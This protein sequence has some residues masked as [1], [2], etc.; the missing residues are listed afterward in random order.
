MTLFRTA[1]LWLLVS[2]AGFTQAAP[3]STNHTVVELLAEN[4]AVIPGQPFWIAYRLEAAPGWHTY[5][6]NPGDSGLPSEINWQLPDGWQVGE[7]YWPSP[8]LISAP[9]FATHA[10][11][12]EVLLL[13][14]ITPPDQISD[15]SIT[16]AGEA[17]WLVCKQL[18]L[19]ETAQLSLTLPIAESATAVNQPRFDAARERWPRPDP[20]WQVSSQRYEQQITL[21]ISGPGPL[22]APIH[23]FANHGDQIEPAAQQRLLRTNQGY[24]LELTVSQYSEQPFT[25]LD[26][27]L[28]SE[29]GWDTPGGLRGLEI[30]AAISSA[31]QPASGGTPIDNQMASAGTSTSTTITS[32][33]GSSTSSL[34]LALALLMA[35]IGGAILNLMPCVFPVLSIKVLSFIDMA[36]GH[37]GHVR[38]HGLL[39]ALGILLSFWALGGLLIGLQQGGAEIGWG[40]QLQSPGFVIALGLLLF[41]LALNLLGVF[42]VGG[43]MMRLAGNTDTGSGY[44][45][46]FATGVL[47]AA[48][49]TPCTA[50]FMGAALGYALTQPAQVTLLIFTAVALGLASPYLLLAEVPGLLDKLPRPGQWM[51][52]FRQL[53]AFP[54]LAS[55]VWL[56][57]VLGRQQGGDAVALLLLTM[58]I[59]A[60]AG[61]LYGLQ[62]RRTSRQRWVD[63]VIVLLL[64]AQLPFWPLMTQPTAAAQTVTDAQWEAFNPDQLATYLADGEAVFIDFTAAWCITCQVNKKLALNRPEVTRHFADNNIRKIRA[65]WTRQDPEITAALA[66]VGRS[67]V[68]TYLYYNRAGEIHLLPELLTPDVVIKA[69]R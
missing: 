11:H 65:D 47:A 12:G 23:F 62:Q 63:G 26:G 43:T 45:S 40:F 66:A 29:S 69:I 22:P 52:T 42:E 57:W 7:F 50:P 6:R 1:L 16:I 20:Q 32:P 8:E 31:S 4:D 55:A 64:L 2:L 33:A 10:Y 21:D 35:F 34:G 60:M 51:N 58:I 37:K 49:A 61:W 30:A 44:W 24:R 28:V 53:L 15:S 14:L 18:C 48:V 46:S 68:P 17:A 36:Q 39:F 13:A 5:W 41:L 56:A 67:G 27:V 3:V 9:P 54:L 25:T 19:R 59:L 38:R